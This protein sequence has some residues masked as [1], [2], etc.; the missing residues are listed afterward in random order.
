MSNMPSAASDRI[1]VT[2]SATL[3]TDK[4]SLSLVD[5]HERYREIAH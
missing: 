2:H 4:T 5:N 1:A 3:T